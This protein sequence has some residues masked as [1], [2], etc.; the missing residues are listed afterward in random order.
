MS[1]YQYFEFQ[2]I[3]HL[4]TPEQMAEL[5]AVSSRAEI[6]PTSFVNVYNWG[7]FK[8]SPHRWIEQYFDAF[9]Y[10]A[11]WGSRRLMFRLPSQ[12]LDS[13]IVVSYCTED[14]LF[15]RYSG[16][17]VIVSFHAEEVEANWAELNARLS[18][19]VLLRSDLIHGDLRCL[20]LGWLLAVQNGEIEDDKSEPPVPP[21]LGQLNAQLENFARFMDIDQ[22]LISSAAERSPEMYYEK[23]ATSDIVKYVR[24]LS[25][26]DKDSMLVRLIGCDEPHVATELKSRVI[27]EVY[28]N[29][30]TGA[31][32]RVEA[33]RT[34][35]QLV[36]RAESMADEER[37]RE[38]D[39][40]LME[41]AR[42]ERERAEQRK[43]Y[44]ESIV[45]SESDL[46]ARVPRL[47]AT[48]QP[49]RYNEAVSL[50]EDL[51]DL[52]N[53]SNTSGEFRRRIDELCRT[54]ARK[55]TFI[56]RLQQAGL[57]S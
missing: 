7:D 6:T 14:H 44:L 53:M 52:S 20:Y 47:I 46:W 13:R 55:V 29:E 21:G 17:H 23:L 28:A 50:L 37:L 8:G 22:H 42:R 3:D 51:R 48:Q 16:D 33:R 18:T 32:A 4:L 12:L 36:A 35:G 24:M 41:K 38:A 45:G 49:K 5:R 43:A 10:L 57:L 15:C 34:V 11:N 9:L 31:G 40:R 25:P 27:K 19:M 1:E 30:M 39:L 2:A 26:R 54:H 56:D